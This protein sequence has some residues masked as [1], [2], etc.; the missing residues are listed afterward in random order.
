[1]SGFRRFFE[2]INI[3][4]EE[5]GKFEVGKLKGDIVFDNVIFRYEENE[6]VFDNFFLKIKV[7]INVVLVGEFGVGKSI[8]CYLIFCFYEILGGKII[9]DNIDIR[10]MFFF[11]FR[12][13]IGIVS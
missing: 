7:G 5:E 6:N 1:M 10:E 2:I 4:E 13:N 3:F 11:L 12:K 8:I 9:I